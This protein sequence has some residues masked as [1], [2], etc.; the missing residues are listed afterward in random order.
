[1]DTTEGTS[2]SPGPIRPGLSKGAKIGIG[3]GVGALL[4]FGTCIGGIAYVARHAEELAKKGDDYLR[5]LAV[6]QWRELRT[7]TAQLMTDEGAKEVY[8]KHPAL[9][10][11]YPTEQA[12]LEV[13]RAWRPRLEPVPET[14]P[15]LMGGQV[16]F[17]VSQNNGTRGGRMMYRNGQAARTELV[18]KDGALIDLSVR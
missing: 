17:Q 5:G 1:M 3:I 10:R 11:N 8:A 6:D 2:P 14:M 9:Q 4:L 15:S 7:I 16:E 13:A 18:W 12:F